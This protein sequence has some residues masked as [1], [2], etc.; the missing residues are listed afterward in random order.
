MILALCWI[1]RGSAKA[2]PDKYEPK[3]EELRGMMQSLLLEKEGKGE[4]VEEEE[5]EEEAETKKIDIPLSKEE[6]EEITKRYNLDDYDEEGGGVMGVNDN[7]YYKSNKEDPNI[8]LH[9]E[10]DEDDLDDF[11]I[12]TSDALLVTATT[13]EDVSHL[14]LHIYE[15]EDKNDYVHHDI[16]LPT[17]PLCLA[18]SGSDPFNIEKSGNFIAVG[19]F[20]PTIEIWNLDVVD[21]LEPTLTLGGYAPVKED[22][23][24]AYISPAARRHVRRKRKKKTKKPELK[25]GSHTT[26]VLGL[27]WNRHHRQILSSCS[28]DNTIK[29]WDV[30]KQQCLQTYTYHQDKVQSVKWHPTEANILLSGSFDKTVCILDVRHQKPV[31]SWRVSADV[32]SIEWNV[33]SPK[34]FLVSTEDGNV[35]C[36][37]TDVPQKPVFTLQAHSKAVSSVCV[38]PGIPD[39]VATTSLDKSFKLWDISQNQPK[40]LASKEMKLGKIFCGAFYEDSPFLL[41]LGGHK[42][43]QVI[44][45]KEIEVVHERFM[46]NK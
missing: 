14:D 38:N 11:T 42:Q 46:Q 13:E 12:R 22:D 1:P 28:A 8:T 37:G 18:W 24:L 33:H 41:A 2:V 15:E 31:A 17:Y 9:E 7:V 40:C 39:F 4:D 26:S 5:E 25:P 29:L 43:L 16:L 44:N 23:K 3:D 32:E 27:S 19:T 36:Y 30:T 6:D 45:T 34:F 21:C 10:E 35:A 20:E